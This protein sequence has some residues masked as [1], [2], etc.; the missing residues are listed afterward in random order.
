MS[1]RTTA[2]GVSALIPSYNCAD[3]ICDAVDSLFAQ[4]RPPDELIV[5]DDASTDGTRQVLNRYGDRIRY[6][7]LE[8][9]RR[10]AGARNVGL[11]MA[12]HSWILFLDAD[13]IL[14]KTHLGNVCRVLDANP[15]LVWAAGLTVI[16]RSRDGPHEPIVSQDL[17]AASINAAEVV[18]DYFAAGASGLAAAMCGYVIRKDVLEEMGGFDATLPH[19]SDSDMWWK[20]ACAYPPI[21]FISNPGYV[22]RRL[23]DDSM[24]AISRKDYAGFCDLLERHL[25]RTDTYGRR[26]A[27]EGVARRA[28]DSI[29]YEALYDD[30]IAVLRRIR[31]RHAR[32]LSLV[33]RWPIRLS[34]SLPAPGRAV[35]R[36][37][38]QLRLRLLGRAP[39]AGVIPGD[40]STSTA[41]S[42]D[43]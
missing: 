5:I 1:L 43:K 2:S 31:Q 23:R 4:T 19:G 36:S 14:L 27:F 17:V 10:P 35:L 7:R 40:P 28:L 20:I 34:A 16:Q 30:D 26:K 32:H 22:Y 8:E 15:S 13:D 39:D 21:G 42:D 41:I 18:E 3:F 6:L 9:N 24:T 38:L 37:V 25:A 33:R 29:A 11:G 12:R